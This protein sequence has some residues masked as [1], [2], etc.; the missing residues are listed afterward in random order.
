MKKVQGILTIAAFAVAIGGAFAS[1]QVDILSVF[2]APAIGGT[3]Q[4]A[5]LP[6]NCGIAPGPVCTLGDDTYYQSKNAQGQ[7]EKEYHFNN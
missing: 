3:C 7:C 5:S 6:P 1:S 4:T 2:K